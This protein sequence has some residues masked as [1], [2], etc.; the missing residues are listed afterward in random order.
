VT[1]A[2]HGLPGADAVQSA[3]W[4][5]VA[6]QKTLADRSLV[7][8]CQELGAG[9]RGTPFFSQRV[10]EPISFSWMNGKLVASRA[11]RVFLEAAIRSGLVSDLRQTYIDLLRHGMPRPGA[12]TSSWQ[13]EHVVANGM[14][15]G[16]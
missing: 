2:G 12:V 13:A 9:E 11:R 1:V 8:A 3:N 7:Q 6:T 4:I 15:I 14:Q 16:N 10:F 5:E